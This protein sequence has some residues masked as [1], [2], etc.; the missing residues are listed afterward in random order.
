MMDT[1]ADAL[2]GYC[3]FSVKYGFRGTSRIIASFFIIQLITIGIIIKIASDYQN[4]VVVIAF[5]FLIWGESASLG[6]F[7]L[8][9][10]EKNAEI[11]AGT[12]T[13]GFLGAGLIFLL[14]HYLIL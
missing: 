2:Y 3:T 1:S 9:P 4:I 12:L 11:V 8:N 5:L 13:F 6:L 10:T 7:I 14:S